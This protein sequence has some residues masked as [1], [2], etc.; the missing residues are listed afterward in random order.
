MKPIYFLAV[1]PLFSFLSLDLFLDFEYTTI[2]GV[3]KQ[4]NE[5]EGKKIMAIVLPVIKTDTTA[6]QLKL[7]DSLS[8]K[9]SNEYTIIGIP[10]I[11][12]GFE[13]DSLE[14][15]KTW[16]RS[17]LHD[18]VVITTGMYTRKD[19]PSQNPLFHW[20]TNQEENMHFNEDA[21]GPGQMFF[22]N[23]AGE[24]YG[25]YSPAQKLNEQLLNSTPLNY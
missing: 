1:I 6:A 14:S 18:Q 17:I 22:I 19:S 15:L 24:L 13:Q 25:V 23:E 5:F 4:F 10:S 7:L 12:D 21:E 20:L 2:D 8:I 11:E 16:Y 9:Y 3:K